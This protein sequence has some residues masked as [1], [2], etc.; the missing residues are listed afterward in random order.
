MAPVTCDV[1]FE[2]YI[3]IFFFSFRGVHYNENPLNIEIPASSFMLSDRCGLCFV[4][5]YNTSQLMLPDVLFSRWFRAIFIYIR[6]NEQKDQ[7]K[8]RSSQGS[9]RGEFQVE[10][11]RIKV[12]KRLVNRAALTNKN[13][14]IR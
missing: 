2:I 6:L 1:T 3:H 9:R 4:L 10:F 8:R 7:E 14:D 13:R 12:C 11:V 5:C